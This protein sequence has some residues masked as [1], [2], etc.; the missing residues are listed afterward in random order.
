MTWV[1]FYARQDNKVT[2]PLITSRRVRM[3]RPCLVFIKIQKVFQDFPSNQIFR[4]IHE[5][6]NIDE[7][8]I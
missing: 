5:V 7:N 8:K 1:D 6:L 3:L 2:I 4:H